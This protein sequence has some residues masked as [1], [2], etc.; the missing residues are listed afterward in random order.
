MCVGSEY[1]LCAV[2]LTYCPFACLDVFFSDRVSETPPTIPQTSETVGGRDI[3][4]TSSSLFDNL[5]S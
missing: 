1:S 2:K 4:V 5:A 3:D